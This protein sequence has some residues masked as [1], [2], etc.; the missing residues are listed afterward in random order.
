MRAM[1]SMDR[2][3][4]LASRFEENRPHLQ[5]VARRILGSVGEA[6]DALQEAW[7]RLTRS[8]ARDIGNL[9]AWLT[10][11]V[12]RVC[13]DTLRSRRSRREASLEAHARGRAE[14]DENRGPEEDVLLA[15]SVG[16]AL[17]VVLE[18]LTP[19]ERVA[20]VLHDLFD[21]SFEEIAPI[22]GK[23]EAATRQLASRARRRVRG[24]ETTPGADP[25]RQRAVVSAFLA[26]T[27]DGDLDALVALLDP[28]V[29]LRADALAVQ[30]AMANEARGAPRIRRDVRGAHAVAEVFSGRAS[31]ARLALVGGA[32]GGTWAPGGKPRAAFSFTV[33]EGRIVGID[34]VMEPERLKEL[35]VELL[36]R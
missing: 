31:G 9:G 3:D 26:A 30:T 20:F 16:P 2:S 5:A 1:R 33:H 7:L 14:T 8:D 12:A 34:V 32:V 4:W 36:D 35:G 18:M 27:R 21:V 11:V 17:L 19:A 29:R 6:E 24:A 22:V 25:A 23:S 28:D 10:T 15:D 13:L